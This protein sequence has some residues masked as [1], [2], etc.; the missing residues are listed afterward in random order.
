MAKTLFKGIQQVVMSTFT[1]KTA[2]EKKGYLWFVREPQGE[3]TGLGDDKF[4]IYF[5]TR[6]Y[7][8]FWEGEHEALAASLLNY[9]DVV[10]EEYYSIF[11]KLYGDSLICTVSVT[12]KLS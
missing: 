10:L 11:E 6:C 12:K 1:G 7:G 2:E 3:N 5:G 9:L 8:S 4:H